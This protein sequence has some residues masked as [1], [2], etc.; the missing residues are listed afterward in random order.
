[1]EA[2][3]VLH[4]HTHTLIDTHAYN[5][6]K[7]KPK[8]IKFNPFKTTGCNQEMKVQ[9]GDIKQTAA[10]NLQGKINFT[11]VYSTNTYAYQ[12]QTMAQ[13]TFLLS[14]RRASSNKSS[15]NNP[16]ISFHTTPKPRA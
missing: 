2:C 7:K 11:D 6:Q 1:M 16:K 9:N 13:N 10:H 3:T 4:A 14:P 12:Y 5:N 15:R 8:Q